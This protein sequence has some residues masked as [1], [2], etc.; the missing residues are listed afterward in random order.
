M[1]YKRLTGEKIYLSALIPDDAENITGWFNNQEITQYL[2]IHRQ[3]KSLEIVKE[4]VTEYIKTGAAFAIFCK[5][6][7][8]II[9]FIVLDDD[10]IEVLIG[11]M[12][13]RSKGYDEE[14][15]EFLLDYGFNL[16]NCGI[17]YITAYSHDKE[18]LTLYEK[19]GFNKALV[20]REVLIHGRN[21]YDKIYFDMLA[22]E[23]LRR[24]QSNA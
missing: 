17:I 3:V 12:E 5:E 1:R 23:Y 13:Y 22:S 9:G 18:A 11:E 8:K 19:M 4:D 6:T 10:S 20:M 7:D 14:A 16:K 24:G 21:K 2:S 15:I